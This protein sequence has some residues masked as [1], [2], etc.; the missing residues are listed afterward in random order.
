MPSGISDGQKWVYLAQYNSGV[1]FDDVTVSDADATGIANITPAQTIAVYPNPATQYINVSC[2]E[3]A[4]IRVM[5]LN[6][7]TIKRLAAHDA[8]QRVDVADLAKGMYMISVENAGNRA[9]AKF[10]KK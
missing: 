2:T 8:L 3:G 10:I 5:D 1:L 6:G 7:R 9:V 4:D